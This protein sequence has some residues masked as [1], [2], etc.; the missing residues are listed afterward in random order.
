MT[1]SN[2]PVLAGFAHG[3]SSD[4]G[5]A[6]TVELMRAVADAHPALDVR[7]GYVDVQQPDAPAVLGAVEPGRPV[8]VVPL[9]LSAGYHVYVDLTEAVQAETDRHTI[10]TGALGPD[11]RLTDLLK[12]RLLAA[13][14]TDDDTIVLAVAGS[15]DDRAVADCHVVGSQLAQLLGREVSVGFL[16]AAHPRLPEAVAAARE[17]HPGSRIMVSSYLLAPG[18][19]QSLVEAAGADAVTQPLLLATGPA[20]EQLVNVVASR[21]FDALVVPDA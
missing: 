16:S 5:R 4:E 1:T 20:P 15:S 7:L 3:T 21:Y 18:Y 19:F 8:V 17:A 12:L 2:A 14:L 13:G 9:L 11:D 6:A 10:L